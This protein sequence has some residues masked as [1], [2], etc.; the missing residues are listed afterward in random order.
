[1]S[2]PKR[3]ALDKIK[4]KALDFSRAFGFVRMGP[5]Y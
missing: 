3:T 4:E 5:D 1:L 2:I